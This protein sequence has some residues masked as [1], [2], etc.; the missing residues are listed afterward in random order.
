MSIIVSTNITKPET[1]VTHSVLLKNQQT[2]VL[3]FTNKVTVYYFGIIAMLFGIRKQVNNFIKILN[4]IVTNN[5]IIITL[6]LSE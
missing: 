5:H 1:Q 3:N 4:S 6:Y 2:R